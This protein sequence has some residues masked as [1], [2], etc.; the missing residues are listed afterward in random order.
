MS[1]IS[2]VWSWAAWAHLDAQHCAD[3]WTRYTSKNAPAS[4]VNTHLQ[5]HKHAEVK[6]NYLCNLSSSKMYKLSYYPFIHPQEPITCIERKKI[7]SSP[8]PSF[9][10][11]YFALRNNTKEKKI[12]FVGSVSK[13]QS[14]DCLPRNPRMELKEQDCSYWARFSILPELKKKKKNKINNKKTL[15]YF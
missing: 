3:A 2:A 6:L 13:E 1:A 4:C 5:W 8:A 12:S 10:M 7:Y 14:F 15:I 11:K 9:Q